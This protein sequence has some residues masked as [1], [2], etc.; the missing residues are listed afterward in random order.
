[1]KTYISPRIE[2]IRINNIIAT[3][4]LTDGSTLGD[5]V[6]GGGKDN[7]FAPT[8]YGRGRYDAEYDLY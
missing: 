7:G 1:M 6:P 3:S 8:R 4:G 2:E 5:I